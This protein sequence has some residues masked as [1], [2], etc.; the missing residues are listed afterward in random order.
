MEKEESKIV[1]DAFDNIPTESELKAEILILKQELNDSELWAETVVDRY[2]KLKA[3]NEELKKRL[4]EILEICN[5]TSMIND[6]KVI[7]IRMKL[8]R[9]LTNK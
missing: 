5:Y 6:D 9:L 7:T 8:N 4:E 3:E 2:N 1:K